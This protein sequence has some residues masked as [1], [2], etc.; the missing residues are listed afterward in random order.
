MIFFRSKSLFHQGAQVILSSNFL[1]RA[2]LE[3]IQYFCDLI[4]KK[5]YQNKLKYSVK[6]NK[7]I[8]TFFKVTQYR[9]RYR[10]Q[11]AT[12]I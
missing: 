3:N 10:I 2:I 4:S 7:K 6:Q 11:M 1:Q 8:K 9:I 12:I 5:L